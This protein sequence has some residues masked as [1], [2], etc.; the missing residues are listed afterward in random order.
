MATACVYIG[1]Y[2]RILDSVGHEHICAVRT[3]PYA[4]D[5]IVDA[6][7]CIW[8]TDSEDEWKG[9]EVVPHSIG[10]GGVYMPCME[11]V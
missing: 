11:L 4:G 1:I 6:V 7:C 2:G 9:A 3:I 10:I 8:N 5:S